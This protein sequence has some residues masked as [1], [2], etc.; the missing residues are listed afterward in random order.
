MVGDGI[1]DAPALACADVGI[2]IGGTGTDIAAEAGDIV[3]MGAPLKPLPLLVRL[4][5]ETMRI[6]RQNIV[7]FAFGV[8]G[9]GVLALAWLWPLVAPEDWSSTGPLLGV[10][11]HQLGSLAVLLNSMRLLWFE[12]RL[13]GPRVER[14]RESFRRVDKWMERYLDVDEALHWL[15]HQWKRVAL[16]V[17]LLLVLTWAASGITQIGPN[18]KGVVLR[19]GKP[20]ATLDPGLAYCWPWPIDR[21]VRVEPDRIRTVEVG[22]RSVQ[23]KT[24][25]PLGWSSTH[26]D[27]AN[28][29]EEEAL[30]ITGDGNLVVLQA[31]VRYKVVAAEVYLFEVT[32]VDAIVRAAAET[33]LRSLVAS[34]S[35][36]E[37]LTSQREQFEQEALKRLAKRCADYQLGVALDGFSLH[38]LHPPQAVVRAYYDVAKAMEEYDTR[39]M[40]AKTT[41]LK[42]VQD[43]KTE[44]D[45]KLRQSKAANDVLKQMAEADADAFRAWIKSRTT[46]TTAQEQRCCRAFLDELQ[47]GKPFFE[48]LENYGQQRADLLAL[49][50]TMVKTLLYWDTFARATAGREV[51]LIDPYRGAGRRILMLV[52]P[53]AFRIPFP[54]LMQPDGTRAPLKTG[55]KDHD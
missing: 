16:A 43:A 32:D 21:V 38:D 6:I 8:N 26:G 7:V 14:V 41:A 25:T 13:T 47:A 4:S 1:N 54:I 5:R 31:T 42:L 15:S 39:K 49:Q 52:D 53:D 11:Y 17:V 34:R 2:A 46:L 24:E 36:T 28:R 29:L 3:M 35:F 33:V 44:Y 55:P 23:G 37:L 51:I 19:F 22:F 30:M 27:S 10:I 20:V 18:E 12:R 45:D 48:A 9:V 40:E 50:D